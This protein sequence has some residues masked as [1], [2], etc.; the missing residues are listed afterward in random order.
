MENEKFQDLVLQRLEEQKQFQ[1][2][3]IKHFQM[4]SGEFKTLGQQAEKP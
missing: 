4:L 2:L 1:G 3:V